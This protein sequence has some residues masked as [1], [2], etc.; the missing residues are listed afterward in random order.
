MGDENRWQ[1]ELLQRFGVYT[2][3]SIASN[4]MTLHTIFCCHFGAK[5]LQARFLQVDLFDWEHSSS[6]RCSSETF[7][8]SKCTSSWRILTSTSHDP[9]QKNAI[10]MCTD[11]RPRF[12][13]PW[14]TAPLA[15]SHFFSKFRFSPTSK[16]KCSSPNG[17]GQDAHYGLASL[18]HWHGER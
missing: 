3:F 1:I 4:A 18:S 11:L 14:R 10:V 2:F 13:T 16:A 12:F 6:F 9:S 5:I 8:F 7:F 15:P 17:D